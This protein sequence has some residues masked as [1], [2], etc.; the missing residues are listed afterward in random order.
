MDESSTYCRLLLCCRCDMGMGWWQLAPMV[1]QAVW[2]DHRMYGFWSGIGTAP[3]MCT[4]IYPPG[5]RQT[6][7]ALSQEEM[8][9]G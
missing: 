7:H 8:G 9:W 3:W 5:R 1:A 6:C 2:L 4:G